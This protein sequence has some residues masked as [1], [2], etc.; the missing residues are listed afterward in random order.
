MIWTHD[1]DFLSDRVLPESRNLGVVVLP[2]G[3]GNEDA[4]L[5]GLRSAILY[6]GQGPKLW[7]K[8]KSEINSSGEL[9]FR[10][11]NPSTNKITTR[12]FR[13][14]ANDDFEEWED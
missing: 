13:V 14:T 11:R 3:D 6:F 2:G 9:K 5:V 10:A 7:L 12:R 1:N 8:T 4:L